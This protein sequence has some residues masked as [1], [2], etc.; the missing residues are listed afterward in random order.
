MNQFH[1]NKAHTEEQAADV[2]SKRKGKINASE[3]LSE[4]FLDMGYFDNIELAEKATKELGPIPG[5]GRFV[6]ALNLGMTDLETE[7]TD[8]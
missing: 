5:M 6:F 7:S 1:L 2:E 8:R 3:A 4:Y